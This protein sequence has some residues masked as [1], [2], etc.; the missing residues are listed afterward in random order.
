MSLV[1]PSRLAPPWRRTSSLL[2]TLPDGYTRVTPDPAHR[3]EAMRKELREHWIK[4]ENLETEALIRRK[5]LELGLCSS[6]HATGKVFKTRFHYK[7]KRKEANLINARYTS[8]YKVM[9]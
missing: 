7:I 3:G 2:S 4:A 1:T 9:E 5:A 6:L 8:S